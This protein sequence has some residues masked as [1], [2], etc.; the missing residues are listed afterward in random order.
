MKCT[1]KIEIEEEEVLTAD[2]GRCTKQH[3][4]TVVT[5]VRFL[6]NQQK[7]DLFIAEIATKNI[8]RQEDISSEMLRKI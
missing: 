4:Q 6:S 7:G 5:N 2:L 3:V 8:D 1:K